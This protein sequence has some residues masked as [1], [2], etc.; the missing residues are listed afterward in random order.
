MVWLSQLN[1]FLLRR[2]VWF[3]AMCSH[4]S[5]HTSSGLPLTH[6]LAGKKEVASFLPVERAEQ[7]HQGDGGASELVQRKGRT[8]LWGGRKGGQADLVATSY[9]VSSA[10]DLS[11]V[12]AEMSVVGWRVGSYANHSWE[13]Q[14]GFSRGFVHERGV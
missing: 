12:L 3:P 7:A 9:E 6:N 11:V 2:A 8:T 1:D 13:F 5:P 10:T 14:Y 4:C